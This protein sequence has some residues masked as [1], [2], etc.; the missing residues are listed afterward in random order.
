VSSGGATGAVIAISAGLAARS[1]LML[2]FM[3]FLGALSASVLVYGIA[4]AAG[5][6]SMTTLLLAGVAVSSFLGATISALILLDPNPDRL[7]GVLYW[8]AGSLSGS[9]WQY[10]RVCV[11]P[12]VIGSGVMLVFARDLNLM[13]LGDD[14]A[15]SSGVPVARVRALLLAT[16]SVVTGAAV[17]VSGTVAFVGLV[18][19]HILRLIAGPDHRVLLPASA[20]GGAVFMV[21][22]DTIA[23]LLVRPAELQVGMVTAFVGAPFFIL[24]LLRNSRNAG[25]FQG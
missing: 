17:S 6:F 14:A 23:R 21:V 24:L 18:V 8:L 25:I 10:V 12:I 22:A 19:P 5:R 7:R 9:T 15:R 3:A 2:P 1:L 11:L 16:A 4:N 20:L 13:V